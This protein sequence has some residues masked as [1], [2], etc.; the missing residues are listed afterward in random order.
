MKNLIFQYIPCLLI[1]FFIFSETCFSQEEVFP[2]QENKIIFTLLSEAMAPGQE[3]TFSN[4]QLN[5]IFESFQVISY[6]EAYPGTVTPRL[7]NR[8]MIECEGC[9]INELKIALEETF[10][11]DLKEVDIEIK[12]VTLD[13]SQAG[14]NEFLQH[15]KNQKTSNYPL[16]CD[17]PFFPSE[18]PVS[19]PTWRADQRSTN[20]PCAWSIT[21]GSDNLIVAVTDIEFVPT[22]S[23]IK[24]IY[25]HPNIQVVGGTQSAHGL[26]SCGAVATIHGNG[27]LANNG[28]NDLP[29]GG[30]GLTLYQSGKNSILL[31]AQD[32]AHIITNSWGSCESWFT[33]SQLQDYQDLI[34]EATYVYGSIVVAGAGNALG[35]NNHALFCGGLMNPVPA[36]L[37]NV[38][39][40]S[41]GHTQQNY[42][43]YF[44]SLFP[45]V[46]EYGHYSY[47]PTVD[48]CAPAY[49]VG[50]P[51]NDTNSSTC[52]DW[53]G[54][55]SPYGQGWGTSVASPFTAGVIG[56]MLSANP[57]LMHDDVDFIL[58]KTAQH[59]PD[60]CEPLWAGQIGAG[61]LDA[62]Q[63]VLLADQYANSGESPSPVINYSSLSL[64]E[65]GKVTL[66]ANKS[67]SSLSWH[68]EI[69][70]I[71]TTDCVEVTSAGEYT[72][73][74]DNTKG[75]TLTRTIVIEEGDCCYDPCQ[76]I[77]ESVLFEKHDF[78]EF[79]N[80]SFNGN[81]NTGM[82]LSCVAKWDWA[83]EGSIAFANDISDFNNGAWN[84]LDHTNGQTS[85]IIGD[86]S[87]IADTRVFYIEE[88]VVSGKAYQFSAWVRNIWPDSNPTNS[89]ALELRVQNSSGL[90]TI[91]MSGILNYDDEWVQ[92]CGT[93][94]PE[95][96]EVVEFQ[97]VALQANHLV[98]FDFGVDDIMIRETEL[99]NDFSVC[100]DDCFTI[101]QTNNPDLVYYLVYKNN[102]T[103]NNWQFECNQCTYPYQLCPG[104]SE[105][106][107]FMLIAV[108]YT[109]NCATY[110]P[111]SVLVSDPNSPECSSQE[112][113]F[114]ANQPEK[115]GSLPDYSSFQITLNPNLVR[116]SQSIDILFENS[117]KG[118]YSLSLVDVNGR[119]F[120]LPNLYIES[121]TSKKKITLPASV[122]AGV[123][124]I[125]VENEF[126]EYQISKL[127]I[128]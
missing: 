33:P 68:N 88:N 75:C 73:F 99:F 58:K 103:G 114:E 124:F 43:K 126:G 48:I 12:P 94:F 28:G 2:V 122:N 127:I 111:F 1:G 16:D 119:I 7:Q 23:D 105:N 44:S 78:T 50:V 71:G 74:F 102:S 110:E 116:K 32:G 95:A 69:S 98:G 37:D 96:N 18:F 35:A 90:N 56:L 125:R 3:E 17:A 80:N 59:M 100:Q 97:V 53:G 101:G 55:G 42:P 57:C 36:I 24:V 39:S 72:L 45:A 29:G 49:G 93:Y 107:D 52:N 61:Y 81:Y 91:A 62:Y 51:C 60:F 104:I 66:C 34:N 15:L 82:L 38:I 47:H 106:T 77:D 108:D 5:S 115:V 21:R 30:I 14:I 11:E 25:Q 79:D 54:T 19:Q 83:G 22:H 123:Y 117:K 8:V 89:P 26:R 20:V 10:P 13:D 63:A 120:K 121:R 4:E 64:C 65:T 9:D 87:T 85:F 40:V 31:A 84:A 76:Y 112:F 118:L 6:T 92:I 70:Q 86:A 41:G 113:N 46:P 67:Y 109:N 128:N 27:G